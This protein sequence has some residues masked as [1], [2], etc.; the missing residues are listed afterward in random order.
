MRSSKLPKCSLPIFETNM[1][2]WKAYTPTCL[3]PILSF[4][5]F[6]A[7]QRNILDT[8]DA[9]TLFTAVSL[10]SLITSPLIAL[11]Q[12]VPAIVSAWHSLSRIQSMI[13]SDYSHQDR[14]IQSNASPNSPSTDASNF[15]RSQNVF[16]IQ[17]ASIGYSTDS[18]VLKDISINIPKSSIT[19]ITGPVGCGKS[20]LLKT[21]LGETLLLSGRM[22]ISSDYG[23]IA[24]CDQ[25]PWLVSG[26]IQDNILGYSVSN[27]PAL[28]AE[29]YQTTLWA[30]C[31]DED[32][33][34]LPDRDSAKV[35]SNGN[36]L[37]GGQ[38]QRIVCV[39][40]PSGLGL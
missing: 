33:D 15:I 32:L 27:N 1:R 30:C 5:I 20:I 2:P 28:D 24:Y 23:G 40:D 11:F 16:E 22:S 6:V 37:S 14:K 25:N 7:T 19:A 35:G 38:K 9:A 26:T 3:S 17:N 39:W 12:I 34:D 4:A 29:W 13:Q 36:S 8:L 18:P 21:L 10:I 31:L